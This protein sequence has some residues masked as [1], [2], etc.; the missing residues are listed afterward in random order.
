MQIYLTA[1]PHQYTNEPENNKDI[2]ISMYYNKRR[3]LFKGRKYKHEIKAN[4]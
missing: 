2:I 4:Q 3:K 1:K